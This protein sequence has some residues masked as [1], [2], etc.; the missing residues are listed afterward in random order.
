M[1]NVTKEYL[2]ENLCEE[3][4]GE[5]LLGTLFGFLAVHLTGVAR[6]MG[7]GGEFI[8]AVG[9]HILHREAIHLQQFFLQPVG[10]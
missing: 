3:C 2:D 7:G 6:K 1:V 5:G 10:M 4:L 9:G 8:G